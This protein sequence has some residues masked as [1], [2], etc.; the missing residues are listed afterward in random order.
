MITN[1]PNIAIKPNN[2]TQQ[3]NK[4]RP[5]RTNINHFSAGN[6]TQ[7]SHGFNNFAILFA[8]IQLIL[9]LIQ[10]LQ[11]NN[12]K[13]EEPPEETLELSD[14]VRQYIDKTYGADNVEVSIV[15]KDGDGQI[16]EGDLIKKVGDGEAIGSDFTT[17][18]VIDLALADTLNNLDKPELLAVSDQI[19][20][21]LKEKHG[22]NFRIVDEDRDGKISAGDSIVSGGNNGAGVRGEVID[23]VLADT[24]NAIDNFSP[25]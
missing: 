7:F 13:P 16:S 11:G 25:I 23:Q 17:G 5:A 8:L 19:K 10:Q 2:Q 4:L 22:S 14:T 15:D 18:K 21:F 9:R 24:L 6:S 1:N 20:E 12:H 3:T